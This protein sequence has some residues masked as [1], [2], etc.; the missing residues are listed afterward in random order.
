[1]SVPEIEQIDGKVNGAFISA[2]HGRETGVIVLSGSSGRVDVDRAALFARAGASALAPRWFGAAGQS[3]GICE[4]PLET[5]FS[6]IDYLIS[7]GCQRTIFVGT[8]K[9]AEAAL[10]T[11][12]Y[13]ERVSAVIAFS[14]T[15]VVWGNIGPG[16]DGVAWPERSSW[17]LKGLPLDFVPA[18]S[19]WERGNRDGLIS[20][21]A[22]FEQSLSA[23]PAAVQ[24]AQIPIEKTA[25]DIILVAGGDDALWPSDMF[26]LELSRRRNEYG[27]PASLVVD[28]EAGHRILLPGEN[29]PRSTLYAHGGSDEA[30]ARLGEAAW[31]E[32]VKLL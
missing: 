29:M 1:M 14:P 13:D 32:I 12:A 5:F 27:M 4:I 7:R 20:Y 30:D 21:R 10:L 23:N 9:G 16:K 8:S 28:N 11:A 19:A 24:R 17:S 3:P 31:R 6:S 26:A 18:V 2:R 22:L 25:A 15:S